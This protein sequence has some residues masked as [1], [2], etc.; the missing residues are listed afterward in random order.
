MTKIGNNIRIFREIKGISQED[1]ARQLNISQQ[2]YGKIERDETK[3]DE[4]RLAKI[5]T[6]LGVSPEVIKHF[7]SEMIM[8]NQ[9]ATAHDNS[10]GSVFNYNPTNDYTDSLK[11]EITFLRE[12]IT[13]LQK[14]NER[15]TELLGKS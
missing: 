11:S 14:Q 2:A 9:T 6:V 13:S 15:L 3:I 12:Q 1:I 4:D 7:N 10:N 5:S 8:V